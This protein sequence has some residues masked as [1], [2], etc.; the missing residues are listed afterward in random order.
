MS[1]GLWTEIDNKNVGKSFY[2][3]SVPR[4]T[5]A[6]LPNGQHMYTSLDIA[7][8]DKKNGYGLPLVR[9][10]FSEQMLDWALPQIHEIISGFVKKLKSDE[11]VAG[12]ILND[13]EAYGCVYQSSS[14]KDIWHGLKKLNVI[15]ILEF[16][17][18]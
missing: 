1:G 3:S 8:F 12:A 9:I 13:F 17:L 2:L 6:L 15:Y 5:K 7:I 10:L 14:I 4:R 16:K 11:D 18:P